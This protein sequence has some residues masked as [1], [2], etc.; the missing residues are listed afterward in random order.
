ML[1]ENASQPARSRVIT[2]RGA[3]VPLLVGLAPVDNDVGRPL[4]GGRHERRR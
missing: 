4:A 2:I 1:A 3:Q